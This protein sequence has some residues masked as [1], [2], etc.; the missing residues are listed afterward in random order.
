MSTIQAR[1]VEPGMVLER[2]DYV[3]GRPRYITATVAAVEDSILTSVETG[4]A[5]K[6]I[7]WTHAKTPRVYAPHHR[8]VVVARL[9]GRPSP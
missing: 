5:D 6:V 1:D 4:E 3:Q 9:I 2:L 8:F 7:T